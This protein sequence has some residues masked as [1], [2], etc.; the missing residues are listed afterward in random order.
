MKIAVW[1]SF[2]YAPK[3]GG[4]FSYADRLIKGIDEYHFS[5][6]LDICFVTTQYTKI[7]N[8]RRRVIRIG[9]PLEKLMAKL[10]VLPSKK[11][12]Q[13]LMWKFFRNNYNNYLNRNEIKLLF[14]SSQF[15]RYV[16]NFPFVAPHW[17]IAHR[18]TFAFP[19]F[20]VILQNIRDNYYTN[21]LP[22]AL[23]IFVESE[24]GKSE[25]IKYTN[26]NEE[27]IRV[28]PL[29][30]GECTSFTVTEERQNAILK[31]L[32]LE[33]GKYF[34]YPAQ[35]IA[36]KNHLNVVKAFSII[37]E[38][39]PDY[40]LIFTGNSPKSLLGNIEYIKSDFYK[41]NI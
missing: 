27:R 5:E 11:K 1:I 7:G 40:K 15:D 6:E 30:A 29:F 20:S 3:A 24:A 23:M 35:F 37:V 31:E 19:E 17:D 18:S 14:Y 34:F 41:D 39:Y 32:G 4:S 21:I 12:F 36:E 13:G 16:K 10:P 9:H 8:L 26:I 33:T 22:R 25:L 38:K 2:N 28:V